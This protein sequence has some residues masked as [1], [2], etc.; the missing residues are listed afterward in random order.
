MTRDEALQL[1]GSRRVKPRRINQRNGE[2]IH[3]TGGSVH[4]C[5]RVDGGCSVGPDGFKESYGRAWITAYQP[6][7]TMWLGAKEFAAWPLAPAP[8]AEQGGD[9]CA[10]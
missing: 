1:V 3:G 9:T 6:G 10:R 5:V 8:Q 4:E 7:E 2:E